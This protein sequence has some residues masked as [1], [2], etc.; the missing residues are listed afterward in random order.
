[1]DSVSLFP[2]RSVGWIYGMSAM[3][4]DICDKKKL[5]LLFLV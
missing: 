1:M 3:I 4:V 5:T 2:K